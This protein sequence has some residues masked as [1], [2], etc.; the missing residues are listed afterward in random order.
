MSQKENSKSRISFGITQNV[1]SCSSLVSSDLVPLLPIVL[2]VANN[3]SGEE[4]GISDVS[5]SRRHNSFLRS[6][7]CFDFPPFGKSCG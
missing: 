6:Y 1:P 3:A 4:K 7:A 2:F 5:C